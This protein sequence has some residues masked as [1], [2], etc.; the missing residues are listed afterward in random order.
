M[1]PR[2][3]RT[4]LADVILIEPGV[5]EDARGFFF[6]AYQA[7]RWREGGIPDVFVQDNHS[8][9]VG[10][11]LRGLHA[12]RIDP[13]AKLVRVVIGEVFDVAVDARVGSPTFGRWVGVRLSAANRLQCYVP[14][15][16]L[17][18]FCVLSDVAEVE[19][20]CS[21]PY[22]GDAQVGVAWDDPDIGIR[23]PVRDPLLSVKDAA[24]PRLRDVTDV[25]TPWTPPR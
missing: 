8:R 21:T 23:W 16:F 11:T 6:E 22:R 17:H 19:Y 1:T 14:P 7:E 10:G 25:L 5:F 9:S 24:Q 15:G 13:Q 12:Q 4:E 2:F 18:G 3:T 20:K